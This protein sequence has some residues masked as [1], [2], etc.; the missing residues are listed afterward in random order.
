MTTRR[1]ALKLVAASAASA[2]TLHLPV[3]ARAAVPA[4]LAVD[5]VASVTDALIQELAAALTREQRHH[6]DDD[7]YTEAR[8]ALVAQSPGLQTEEGNQLLIRLGWAVF[9]LVERG[10]DQSIRHSL[11]AARLPDAAMRGEQLAA[12]ARGGLEEPLCQRE[13]DA[14]RVLLQQV[15]ER[16]GIEPWSDALDAL[17]VAVFNQ[18][19]QCWDWGIDTG[20]ELAGVRLYETLAVYAPELIAA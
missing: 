8:D 14:Y 10:W 5:P 3:L 15:V 20:A 19:T 12:L 18:F 16:S 6:I 17:D 13:V 11:A 2:A 4:P 9:R 1:S 7:P